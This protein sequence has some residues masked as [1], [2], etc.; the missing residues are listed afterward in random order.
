MQIKKEVSRQ[1]E[2]AKELRQE[3]VPE[4]KRRLILKNFKDK[5]RKEKTMKLSIKEGSFASIMTGLGDAYIIPYAL[6]LNANNLQ[7]GL[8]RSFSGLLPPISQLYG[9]KL[10]ERYSR[11]RIIIT[12]ISLQALMWLPVLLLSLFFWK[13]FLS[14]YLLY[15]LI[16]FYTL[17]AMLG[18]IAIPA[19]FS[20]M[21]DIVPENIRGRYFGKRNKVI[22]VVALISTLAAAFLLDFF[23]TKGLV[24]LGF[25]LLFFAASIARFISACLLKRHYNPKFK[26]HKKYYFSFL[27]FLS[28]IKKY[29]FTKFSFFVAFMYLSVTIAGPFFTVYMLTEL[30]FNYITYMAIILASSFASLIF[31]PIWGRFSDKYG[32]RE[33][34]ILSSIL[35]SIM[36]ILW[37]FSSSPYYLIFPMLLVGIG[38]AGFHLASFSFIYDSVSL[39]RRGLC[40]TYLNILVG[41]GIFIG[42]IFGGL[43]LQKLP[44]LVLTVN[45]FFIIFLISSAAR[46]LTAMLFL[47]RIKEVRKVGKFHP[48]LIFRKMKI[49]HGIVHETVHNMHTRNDKFKK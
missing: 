44:S 49:S 41:I 26:L 19:W 1:R 29:N 37:F 46:T 39:E 6:A 17:Y 34:L 22:G 9:S 31:M 15:L 35:I 47:P 12:Y 27:Q 8:L 42:S 32:R 14:N 40:L 7:I 20:L 24:L 25:S 4:K 5:E 18:S 21:G 30:G 45:K 13:N 10:M 23:K 28:G 2:L 48:I 33:V 16:V 3:N 43:L 38:W 11:K 36:P